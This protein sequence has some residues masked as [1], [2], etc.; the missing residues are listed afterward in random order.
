V[1]FDRAAEYYDA[2]RAWSLEAQ[3]K[4]V[5]VLNRELAPRGRCLEIGVG[6]GRVGLP[7]YRSGVDMTGI[8]LSRPMMLKLLEKG[9]DDCFPLAQATATRLPFHG[10]VFGSG[11]IVHVLHLISA[12]RSALDELVRVVQPGGAIVIS[13][14][15]DD[16]EKPSMW[17]DMT[18][19][20]R[21]EA[22]LPERFPGFNRSD[23][24]DEAMADLGA[25]PRELERVPERKRRTA[26]EIADLMESGVLSFTWD[27]DPTELR[28]AAQRLRAWAIERYGSLDEVDANEFTI[29]WRA[30]DLP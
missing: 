8:D 4:T 15:D 14:G 16:V 29:P 11:L 18:A 22:R 25:T 20:F 9:A 30:Y 5:E 1:V 7:L 17:E 19:Q 2:T 21:K 13:I 24:I 28:Y 6:T 26:R 10:D 3:I 27:L 12:W 23:E